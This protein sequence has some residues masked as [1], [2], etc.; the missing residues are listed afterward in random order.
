[1]N[2]RSLRF[3]VWGLGLRAKG[4]VSPKPATLNPVSPKRRAVKNKLRR[5]TRPVTSNV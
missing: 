4:F 3:R 1:M 2:L 5:R